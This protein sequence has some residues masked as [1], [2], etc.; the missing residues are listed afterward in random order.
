MSE[1]GRVRAG[2]RSDI[3]GL[4]AWAVLVVILYHFGVPGFGG[5]FV[6][7]DV[8]FVISG[9]LMTGII[10][11]GLE[12][13]DFSLIDF[14]LARARRIVPALLVLCG[15]L[16]L[17]GWWVLMPPDYE[18]LGN[19][20]AY[21]LSFLS[22][23]GL[24]REA[25]YFDA[26]SHEKWL[27]HTWS[28]SVEWQFYLIL[29]L[30]LWAMWKLRPGRRG[31]LVLV[32]GGLL[33]SWALCLLLTANEPRKA[34]FF[35][36]TRAWEM[37]GGGLVFLLAQRHALAPAWRRGLQ[38]L[39]LLLIAAAVLVFDPR[40]AWPGW[41]AGLPVVASMMVIAAER[42]TPWLASR[43]LQWLGDRSYSLYLW[44]W[45][46]YVALAY[47]EWQDRVPAL[48]AA[49]ALTLLLG[50]AS[51]VLVENPGRRL[52]E[53][54]GRAR[55]AGALLATILLV[56]LPAAAVW[57]SGGVGGRFAPLL[58]QAA[59]EA[60]N[61]NPRSQDCYS[62]N[63][64]PF[65]SCLHGGPEVRAVGIG[66][67]HLSATISALAQARPQ[68]RDGVLEWSFR[69]CQYV[70]GMKSMSGEARRGALNY[71]CTQFIERVQ[72]ELERLPARIPV[73]IVGRYAAPAFDAGGAGAQVPA[74][75]FTRPY[76]RTTPEF[77]EEFGQHITSA[78]CELA[79]Q[80]RVYLVRPYPEIGKHVPKILSRRM[81]RGAMDDL[82]VSLE[83]YRRRNAWIW[84]AQDRAQERCGVR[85]LDPLPYLCHADRCD[86]SRDGR[87]LYFDDNHLSEYGNKLLVPMFARVFT[88][89]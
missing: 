46:V 30:T 39:G 79:K 42:S 33:A 66:D 70:P 27:L 22:N 14:Y 84:A 77:L 43:P 67:S 19:H 34:F 73:V 31:Q 6:G 13:G 85:L 18:I 44:H 61:A 58:E 52:M 89:D 11:R 62:V 40:S 1:G 53:R 24:W 68:E 36:H 78:A 48:V 74:V 2:F 3:N 50:H 71:N 63:G 12:R 23:V 29:P 25:G 38:G 83:E 21:S 56:L 82:S 86:G 55:G 57:R 26:A 7:V 65:P 60:G 72:Q 4:R 9:F 16:L 15:V 28:L 80:R 59:A 37:L 51:Y 41:R 45:P 54:A 32:A 8:F 17:L 69:G 47:L 35:L 49:L 64:R 10:V 75:Y 20:I 5:G 81:H 88:E 87:P 76:A